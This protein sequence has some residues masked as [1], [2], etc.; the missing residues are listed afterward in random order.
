M[1]SLKSF[2]QTAL[3]RQQQSSGRGP[4]LP[5]MDDMKSMASKAGAFAFPDPDRPRLDPWKG[6]VTV[7]A[8]SD[9]VF[10][11]SGSLKSQ[12]IEA[13]GIN[14][15]LFN[16]D[17]LKPDPEF[18]P[19]LPR[20][21]QRRIVDASGDSSLT[22][23]FEDGALKIS[24]DPSDYRHLTRINLDRFGRRSSRRIGIDMQLSAKDLGTGEV[25]DLGTQTIN[26][27]QG[28]VLLN[29]R[30]KLDAISHWSLRDQYSINVETS[31][32]S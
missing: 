14:P 15:K 11:L 7:K 31:F 27:D 10:E 3:L 19:P 18:E 9:K 29:L 12:L 1:T 20:F 26:P 6:P 2:F 5:V 30:D 13:S 23:V 25:I 16:P 4:V 8:P 24:L 28:S 21:K 22:E 32:G 17:W